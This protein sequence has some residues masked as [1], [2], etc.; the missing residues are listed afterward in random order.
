MRIE[1]LIIDGFKRWVEASFFTS[2]ET[3]VSAVLTL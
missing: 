3:T 2:D 1:E